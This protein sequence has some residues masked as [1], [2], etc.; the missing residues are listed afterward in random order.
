M[1][2]P[3]SSSSHKATPQQVAAATLRVLQR[4]VPPAVPGIVFLSGGQSES[5]ATQHL[6]LINKQPGPKPWVLSF[7]YGRALQAS[8]LKTWRGQEGN[9]A[10]AQAA[11][12]ERAAANGAAAKTA[13]TAAV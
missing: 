12:M 11:F 4:T 1:I 6:A 9:V 7:S 2:L 3:G 8:A 13:A 5:E 10:A